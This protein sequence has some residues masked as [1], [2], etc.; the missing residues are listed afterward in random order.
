MAQASGKGKTR[1]SYTIQ[2]KKDVVLHA[3]NHSNQAAT[4]KF[5]IEPKCVREWKSVAQK[6]NTVKVNRRRLD[7]GG[8]NSLDPKLEEEVACWV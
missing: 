7:G 3:V 5:N 6:F 1:Q 4:S 8:R 2:F